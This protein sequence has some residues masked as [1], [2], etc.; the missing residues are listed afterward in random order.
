MPINTI[1]SNK[2]TAHKQY[3]LQQHL[4]YNFL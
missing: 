1:Y 2:A 4:L 3:E